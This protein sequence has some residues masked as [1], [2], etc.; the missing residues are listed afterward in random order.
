[1]RNV[2][3]RVAT[4]IFTVGIVTGGIVAGAVGLASQASAQAPTVMGT[5]LVA[6]GSA[7]VRLQPCADPAQGPLC[8]YIAALINPVGP[9]G[10]KVAPD[11]AIDFRNPDPA[12]RGR[13]VIGSPVLWGFK[14]GSDANSFEGGT[15]Y[16]GENGKTY[17][18]NVALQPDG[19]LRL[20]GYVGLP[21]FGETQVWTR[22]K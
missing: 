3:T 8:G 22:V 5:W 20:R 9:D 18:A 15:I 4:A 11:A 14:Q 7:Q 13:K 17:T 12:L 16:S 10:T 19:M 1:M 2:V 21:M 6:S